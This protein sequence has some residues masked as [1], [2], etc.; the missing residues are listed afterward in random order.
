MQPGGQGAEKAL[1]EKQNK[2]S[3]NAAGAYAV[4]AEVTKRRVTAVMADSRV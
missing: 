1:K 4:T 2:T 3:V